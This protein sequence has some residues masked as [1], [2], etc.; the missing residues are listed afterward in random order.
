VSA[1][2]STGGNGG[3]PDL[4]E[5]LLPTLQV[6]LDHP[7]IP[8]LATAV[9]TLCG[10]QRL[11][12]VVLQPQLVPLS[13]AAASGQPVLVVGSSSAVRD[14]F[15]PPLAAQGNGVF[16]VNGSGHGTFS[17]AAAVASVQVFADT[18]H[19]RTVV[20]ATTSGTWSELARLYQ[21]LGAT[22]SNWAALT[23]DVVAISAQGRVVNLSVRSGGPKVFTVVPSSRG[24]YLLVAG[25][26]VLA[27]IAL[28]AAEVLRRRR[29]KARPSGSAVEITASDPGAGH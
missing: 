28:A 19:Q 14:D 20:L 22:P 21:H 4:P 27:L 26:F 29:R 5:S 23:G 10:I 12:A 15:T 7:G 1:V 18:A 25:I 2:L 16:K 24:I 3:F 8:Q 17:Q 6:A 9:S 11:S 13:T